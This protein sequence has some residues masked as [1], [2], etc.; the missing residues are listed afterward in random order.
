MSWVVKERRRNKL[1][2]SATLSPGSR[3]PL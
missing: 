3:S 2:L 1:T